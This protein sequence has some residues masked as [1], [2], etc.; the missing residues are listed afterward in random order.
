MQKMTNWLKRMKLIPEYQN[1]SLFDLMRMY[2]LLNTGRI[3]NMVRTSISHP[4]D[5]VVRQLLN[6]NP[7]LK[8][9]DLAEIF[10]MAPSSISKL[11]TKNIK[12]EE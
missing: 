8:Q 9:K 2:V 12:G 10:N 5:E 7:T 6:D 1:E 4:T 11:K 3:S